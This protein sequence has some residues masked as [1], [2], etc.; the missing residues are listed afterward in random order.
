[1]SRQ[2]KFLTP[3]LSDFGDIMVNVPQPVERGNFPDPEVLSYYQNREKRIFSI[4]EDIDDSTLWVMKEIIRINE[5]DKAN[6]IPIEQRQPIKLRIYTAGGALYV[7]FGLVDT[8][9]ASQTPVWTYNMGLCASCGLFIFLAGSR[10]FTFKN[11][12]F[13]MHSGSKTG[14]DKS[15]TYEQQEQDMVQWKSLVSRMRDF[16]KSR[17]KVPEKQY[18]ANKEKDW[19]FWGDQA[20]EYA[21][22]TDLI[23]SLD[24]L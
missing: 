13:L 2:D 3:S 21:V 19:W 8:M 11:G 14:G 9:L 5:E 4:F 17:T 24:Q 20:I 12:S 18:K 16:F 15:V 7:G 22:A 6:N 23:T 1:M 10:R